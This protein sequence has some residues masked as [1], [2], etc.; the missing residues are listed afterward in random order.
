MQRFLVVL[1]AVLP[2][3]RAVCF[4]VCRSCLFR[5]QQKRFY[6]SCG[7]NL[8]ICHNNSNCKEL[9]K[10]ESATVAEDKRS[11]NYGSGPEA[12]WGINGVSGAMRPGTMKESIAAW[13]RIFALFAFESILMHT[14][15]QHG[16]TTLC[17]NI[18]MNVQ[19][20][21]GGGG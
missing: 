20:D 6:E 21:W 9:N 16:L 18:I 1:N 14:D 3:P 13:G 10:R 5:L 12:E 15:E 7:F 4:V 2:L 8:F 19:T 17:S 11:T